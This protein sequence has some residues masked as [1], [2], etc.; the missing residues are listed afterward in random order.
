MAIGP[1]LIAE[2]GERIAALLPGRNAVIVTDA[3]VAKRHL[4]ALRASLERA[5]IDAAEIVVPPGEGFEELRAS[6]DR[7]RGDPGD[8]PRA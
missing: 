3:N 1:G 6:A 4:P 2:A 5:G 8:A 7:R